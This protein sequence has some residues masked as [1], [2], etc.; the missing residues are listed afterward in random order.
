MRTKY[1]SN[2]NKKQVL[3]VRAIIV[4]H[5]MNKFRDFFLRWKLEAERL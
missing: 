1:V 2:L 3:D 4:H 5:A